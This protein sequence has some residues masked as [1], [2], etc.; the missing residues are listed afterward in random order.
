MA[1]TKG[2]DEATPL[3]DNPAVMPAKGGDQAT[4]LLDGAAAANDVSLLSPTE[5][6]AP[7][8]STALIAMLCA[9]LCFGSNSALIKEMH[10][11][12]FLMMELRF[13]LQWLINLGVVLWRWRSSQTMMGDGTEQQK[14]GERPEPEALT[15][16]L[17][18]P[19]EARRWLFFWVLSQFAFMVFWYSALRALPVGTATSILFSNTILIVFFAWLL[20]GE[21]PK[22][23]G[24][25]AVAVVLAIAGVAFVQG[26]ES[27]PVG[28]ATGQATT[29]STRGY[30]L[31]ALAG[32][33]AAGMP[34]YQ[35]LAVQACG[36]EGMN[37]H[38]STMEHLKTFLITAFLCPLALLVEF[39]VTEHPAF[40]DDD[41]LATL[42][43]L[44]VSALFVFA[45]MGLQTFSYT[46]A[47]AGEAGIML[48]I[49]IPY[50][51]VLQLIIFHRQVTPLMVVGATAV[52]VAGLIVLRSRASD[53]DDERERPRERQK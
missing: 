41:P 21:L 6:T 39:G 2:V 5:P 15:R 23:M 28:G 42:A 19:P 35:K 26:G 51:M 25:F 30:V 37:L 13:V 33:I 9:G 44:P 24:S 1:P 47:G 27:D 32:V 38:W 8:H 31:V 18:G 50:T 29:A 17:F 46:I 12:V 43:L 52:L 22:D 4:Q 11:N 16:L 7:S 48:Y 45:G 10:M 34:S 3:L 53:T 36:E 20:L 49:E 14:G 40:E